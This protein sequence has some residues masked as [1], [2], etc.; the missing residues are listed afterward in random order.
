MSGC[1][2][3]GTVTQY[4][5]NFLDVFSI[6]STSLQNEDYE[7]IIQEM[8]APDFHIAVFAG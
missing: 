3:T 8:Q 2:Q 7:L 6:L 4:R 1:N 5:V